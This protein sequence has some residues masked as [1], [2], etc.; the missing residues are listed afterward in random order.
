MSSAMNTLR[1]AIEQKVSDTVDGDY[2]IHFSGT[3]FTPPDGPWL[4]ATILFGQSRMVTGGTG[5]TGN[6]VVGLLKLELFDLAGM[7]EGTLYD[8]ADTLRNAFSRAKVGAATFGAPSGPR[9]V[10]TD[11]DAEWEQIDVTIPFEAPEA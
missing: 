3:N 9:P 11:D 8:Y 6:R 5:V 1:A 7:G 4:R 2:P 10:N